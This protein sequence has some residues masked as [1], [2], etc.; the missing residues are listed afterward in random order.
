MPKLKLRNADR[1]LMILK[2][3]EKGSWIESWDKPARRSLG[4]FPHPFRIALLAPPNRGKTNVCKNLFLEHQKTKH[5][6]KHLVVI[7][8]SKNS[9]E[10]DDLEPDSVL[11]TIPELDVFDGKEK[12]CII[13]DDYEF[14]KGDAEQ[15]RRLTTLMR[16]I[17]SH[18]NVS[19]FICYQS[20]FNVPEIARKCCNVFVL[21]KPNSNGELTTIANRCGLDPSLMKQIFKQLCDDYYDSCTIDLTKGSPAKLRKNI[22]Q[23]IDVEL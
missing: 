8:A 1:E 20:F 21:W 5:K 10:Y 22:Y 13:I 9:K 4:C 18:R 17:S 16:F 12:I 7:T 14:A 23:P 19:V 6:F 3:K 2:N 11:D 15:L